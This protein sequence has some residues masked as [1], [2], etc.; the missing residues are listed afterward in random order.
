M[1]CA[2]ATELE[3]TT[4]LYFN[5]CFRCDVSNVVL[6]SQLAARLWNVSQEMIVNIV[7]RDKLWYDLALT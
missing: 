1:F 5:N 4:G 2:T 6:D 7:K 3:G